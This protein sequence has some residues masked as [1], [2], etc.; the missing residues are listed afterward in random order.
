MTKYI[1]KHIKKT[2]CILSKEI[3]IPDIQ[4]NLD[5]KHV[6]EIYNFENEYY[7]LH[8]EYC[9]HGSISIAI[10]N[11]DIKYLIDGQ[12]RCAAYLKLT[13]D[14]PERHIKL[15]ID[16]YY[17]NGNDN[18]NDNNNN[19]LNQIYKMVNEHKENFIV[20]CSIDKYKILNDI[21][22]FFL[23]NFNDYIKS[24]SKPHKPYFNLEFIK[25]ELLE[26]N[27]IDILN[28][29][30]SDQLINKIINL[31]KYYSTIKNDTFKKWG[32]K[33]I[34]TI[35]QKI[36]DKSNKYYLGIYTDEWIYRLID[37]HQSN[38]NANQIE[39][40]VMDFRVLINKAL[41]RKVWSSYIGNLTLENGNVLFNG[42]C[43]CCKELVSY[44][45]FECGHVEPVTRGGKTELENLRPI[46]RSCNRDMGTMNLEEFVKELNI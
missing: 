11:N 29:T 35:K 5:L 44:D 21:E 28:I 31:N 41:R 46:C 26:S 36:N 25:N 37:M 38:K 10:N 39:H 19:S 33:N 12:H 20:K 2:D 40:L 8:N 24:S 45:D 42:K 3:N 15:T 9:L 1:I 27:I 23:N 34:L 32:I 7:L 18:D 6:N 30:N 17:F 13:N 4:R 14:Y 16:Y 43:Y 22:K